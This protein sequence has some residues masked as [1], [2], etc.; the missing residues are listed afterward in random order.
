MGNGY[1]V[2]LNP[3]GNAIWKAP[4]RP[5]KSSPVL[6]D[7]AVFL[8]AYDEGKLYTQCF[9]RRTG[10]LLW[11]RAVER[12]REA[13]LSQLNEPAAHTPTTDGESVYVMYRDVGLLSYD[14]EG[15]LRWL[16]ELGSFG[17]SNG[18]AASPVLAG[19]KVI[20]QA[21]QIADSYIVAIDKTNGE[22]VWRTPR[23]ESE[24][25][26]TPAVYGDEQ[27]LTTSFGWLGAHRVA[28]GMRLWG[29]QAL[30]PRI[31]A[32]PVVVADSVYSFGYGV[33]SIA[34]FLQGFD[35]SDKDGDGKLKQD[36]YQTNDFLLALARHAGNRD[37]IVTR[38]EILVASRPFVSPSQLSAF[39]LSESGPPRELWSYERSFNQVVP[40]PLV[41]E[42][43]L[44]FV[45]NGGI[46]ESLDAETGE[47][48]KRGRLRDAIG[49][50]SA[51]PVAADGKIYLASEDG[52]ITTLAAGQEWKVLGTSDLEADIFAT[53]AL[54]DGAIF[55]RTHQTLYC[56]G[57]PR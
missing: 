32:S 21:D 7:D 20:V 55:V 42:G 47:V 31:I 29:L 23:E 45:R 22:I 49:G 6:T 3:E 51:S 8:T 5:G 14:A 41:Y 26:A 24:G 37:G 18:H 34:G 56:F 19:D 57:E 17:N 33:H 16:T 50:Y 27:V 9:D 28:D 13:H 43:V 25:W 53:P 38:D 10:R 15:E 11:E 35:A 4:V 12:K 1:P 48:L 54:S 40:S 30:S 44:Y 52:K 39:R 2:L 36:E 46:L